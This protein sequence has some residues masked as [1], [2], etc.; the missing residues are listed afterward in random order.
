VGVRHH[1]RGSRSGRLRLGRP[2]LGHVRI[3]SLR[4]IVA[5]AHPTGEDAPVVAR[6]LLCKTAFLDAGCRPLGHLALASRAMA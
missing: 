3:G 6:R 2:A 1:P 5:R 4:G